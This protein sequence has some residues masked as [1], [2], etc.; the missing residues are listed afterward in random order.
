MLRLKQLIN[1]FEAG[2]TIRITVK[3]KSTGKEEKLELPLDPPPTNAKEPLAVPK[4]R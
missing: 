1:R 2:E 3:R 4:I